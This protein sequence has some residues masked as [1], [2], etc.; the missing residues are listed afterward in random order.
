MIL[1]YVAF[2]QLNSRVCLSGKRSFVVVSVEYL[3]K[4][5]IHIYYCDA[6]FTLNM[7]DQNRDT[8]DIR[9]GEMASHI[10]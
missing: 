5:S 2:L 3:P 4:L 6:I 10:F 1:R 8:H 9:S 7:K